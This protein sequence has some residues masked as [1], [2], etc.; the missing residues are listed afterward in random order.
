MNEW[1]FFVQNDWIQRCLPSMM[2][3][4]VKAEFKM[5]AII[6]L[7]QNEWVKFFCKCWELILAELRDG[8]NQDERIQDRLESSSWVRMNGFESV[9]VW[10][11]VRMELR[12]FFEWIWEKRKMEVFQSRMASRS[13]M[14]SLSQIRT[15]ESE[16]CKKWLNQEFRMENWRWF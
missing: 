2:A 13:K 14:Q 9:L 4:W 5:A 3:E 8:L 6:K 1:R 7:S 11:R 15:S 12:V 10:V 16:F